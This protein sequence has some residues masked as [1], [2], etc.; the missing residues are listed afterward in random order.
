MYPVSLHFATPRASSDDIRPSSRN[1]PDTR[2]P[3]THSRTNSP[4]PQSATGRASL[5]LSRRSSAELTFNSPKIKGTASS[6]AATLQ[7]SPQRGLSHRGSRESMASAVPAVPAKSPAR[8]TQQR[9]SATTKATLPTHAG[10]T[11]RKSSEA[12][13]RRPSISGGGHQPQ[14]RGTV[15]LQQSPA[16]GTAASGL[17]KRGRPRPDTTHG[18]RTPLQPRAQL[19]TCPPMNSGRSAQTSRLV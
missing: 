2:S 7:H 14:Y 5:D 9:G 4:R 10:V 1:L 19:S 17:L 15:D 18:P 12:L 16:V 13:I 11:P 6:R 3:L 8:L